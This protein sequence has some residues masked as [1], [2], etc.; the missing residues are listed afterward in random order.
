MKD[1]IA[2]FPGYHITK[3]GKVYSC[4]IQGG[5]NKIGPW[6]LRKTY[7]TKTGHERIVLRNSTGLHSTLVSRLVALAYIPNP[8]NLPVVMHLDDNGSNNH[9]ENLKWGTYKENTRDSIN[10]SRWIMPKQGKGLDSPRS[11]LSNQQR[12]QRRILRLYQLGFNYKEIGTKVNIKPKV[13]SRFISFRN[14]LE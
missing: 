6:I 7:I 10:K 11:I 14:S 1:N 2:G 4:L 12:K 5:S 3:D 13:I 9:I 8:D